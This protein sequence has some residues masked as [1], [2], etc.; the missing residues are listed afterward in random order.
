[1]KIRNFF[2]SKYNV[3]KGD[4]GFSC[5]SLN[6]VMSRDARNNSIFQFSGEVFRIARWKVACMIL[7]HE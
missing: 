6:D 5:V 2:G 1:M 3:R 7:Q 4:F